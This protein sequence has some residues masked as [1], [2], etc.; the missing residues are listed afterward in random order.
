MLQQ[1]DPSKDDRAVVGRRTPGPAG[2]RLFDLGEFD[3]GFGRLEVEVLE[4]TQRFTVAKPCGCFGAGDRCQDGDQNP[5]HD[6]TG[7]RSSCFFW[8]VV[9]QDLPGDAGTE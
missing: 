2:D 8:N 6:T 9:H 3:A 5:G 1:I 4:G 7:G